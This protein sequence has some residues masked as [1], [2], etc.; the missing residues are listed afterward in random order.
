MTATMEES[1]KTK[2]IRIIQDTL[3]LIFVVGGITTC[4]ASIIISD[5]KAEQVCA[6]TEYFV[7][8]NKDIV[9]R[10]STMFSNDYHYVIYFVRLDK[11]KQVIDCSTLLNNKN[12]TKYE[13]DILEVGEMYHKSKVNLKTYG[14]E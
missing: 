10:S 8:T 6:E 13:Y 14:Y 4:T 9:D 11:D 1:I 2:I 12:I 5:N 3:F 7:V